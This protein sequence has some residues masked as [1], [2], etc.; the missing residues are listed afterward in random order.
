[1]KCSKVMIHQMKTNIKDIWKRQFELKNNQIVRETLH[2]KNDMICYIGTISASGSKLFQIQLIDSIK[3]NDKFLKRFH[4]VEVRIISEKKGFNEITIILSDLDLTDIFSMFI[5]D[6][7]AELEN[8]EN[9]TDAPLCVNAKIN[10]WA[11]LFA[12][13][14][15]QI[16]SLERQ[17]GLFGELTVLFDLLKY[18][19]DYVKCFCSWTGP[20]GTN[21]DFSNEASALEIKTT[22]ATSPTVNISNEL[23]LDWTVLSNL[24]LGV[25][26]VDELNNGEETLEKVIGNIK[27]R[28]KNY[29]NLIMLF[30][31]KLEKT[32]IPAGE[33]KIYNKIG[34]VI[35]SKMFYKVEQGFPVLINSVINNTSIHHV[36]YQLDVS[37]IDSFSTDF[38][39]I[40]NSF[41]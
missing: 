20:E 41:I 24:Y 25:I 23:Q 34:F 35:R 15:G 28:I 21:Q 26:H 8:L 27:N 10:N 40:K 4:G 12:K 39:T 37:S 9:A 5:E 33:E 29:T 2:L 13:I 3:I 30:E 17:R 11:R 31:D 22:K 1:M 36:K 6:L 14:S 38:E 18:S 32:G 19:S 7:I 16:L